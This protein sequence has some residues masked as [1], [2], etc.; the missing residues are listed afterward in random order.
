MPP[1]RILIADDHR[2]FRTGLVSMFAARPDVEVVGQ[3]ADGAEAVQKAQELHP[4][5]VLLDVLMPVMDGVEALRH[6]RAAQ[7][8]IKVIMLT[9]SEDDRNM[10]EALQAGAQGYLLKTSEPDDLFR[11][12]RAAMAGQATVS[13]LMAAGLVR[14]MSEAGSHPAGPD[15][16]TPREVEV[17]RL[18]AEGATNK[19][20]ATRL[21]ITVNTVKNHLR[22]ILAKLNLQNRTQAASYALREGIA[23][24]MSPRETTDTP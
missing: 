18:V 23:S 3:A 7:P 4:D 6:I 16:L 2:L 10:L 5:L 1:I 22:E 8:D 17:L 9:A 15:A 11:S 12:L 20:I 19:E 14:R 13:G 24:P 21:C